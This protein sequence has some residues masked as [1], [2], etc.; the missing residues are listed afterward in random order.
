MKDHFQYSDETFEALFASNKL[1]PSLFNHEAHLRLAWIHIT[2]YGCEQAVVNVCEQIESYAH[3]LGA[4]DTYNRT[5]TMAAVRAVFH[6]TLKNDINDFREFINAY[7]RLKTNLKALLSQHYGID[8][9]NSEIAK[10]IFLQPDL[11][12]FD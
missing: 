8:I 2:K 9:F 4:G 3:H 7:P 6:F 11:L 5:V 10:S 1:E 12:P